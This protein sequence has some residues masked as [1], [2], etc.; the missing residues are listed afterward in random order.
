MSSPT[1]PPDSR[2]FIPYLSSVVFYLAYLAGGYALLSWMGALS[3]LGRSVVP[4]ASKSDWS[5]L[6]VDSRASDREPRA[7]A[8]GDVHHDFVRCISDPA[9]ADTIRRGAARLWLL[10]ILMARLG[11]PAPGICGGAG[12]CAAHM[13][14]WKFWT[15]LSRKASRCAR[16]ITD[17]M[18]LACA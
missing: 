5:R 1:Q 10:P 11:E 9:V 15:C 16:S 8:G 14:Y 2:G 4:A 7:A 17:G 3:A 13:S 18:A 12:V 6:A